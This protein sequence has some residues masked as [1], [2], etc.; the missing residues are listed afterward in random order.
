MLQEYWAST[1]MF[2]GIFS[3]CTSPSSI[4]LTLCECLYYHL[5]EGYVNFS[6]YFKAS[7]TTLYTHRIIEFSKT[8]ISN[9]FLLGLWISKTKYQDVTL[10]KKVSA[11]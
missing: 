5:K 9:H 1:V 2:I 11:F 7:L 3:Q 6:R 8:L 4:W 10:C